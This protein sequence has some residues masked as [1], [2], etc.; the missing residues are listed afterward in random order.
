MAD[1]AAMIERQEGYAPSRLVLGGLVAWGLCLGLM[2]AVAGATPVL[3]YATTC[4][5]M[6]CLG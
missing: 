4:L 3:R 1:G 6:H 2:L 5:A